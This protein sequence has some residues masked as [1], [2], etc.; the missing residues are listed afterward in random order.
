MTSGTS[1]MENGVPSPHKPQHCLSHICCH[2]PQTL[3]VCV[4]TRFFCP[5]SPSKR[6]LCVPAH[7]RCISGLLKNKCRV[8]VTHQLQHLRA[9]DHIVLLQEVRPTST[10]DGLSSYPRLTRPCPSGSNHGSGHLQGAPAL[11]PRRGV[12][13]EERRGAG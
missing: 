8:L 12:V 10:R 4:F 1:D 5:A 2:G 13:D 7:V 3:C 6:F 9:A 11:G